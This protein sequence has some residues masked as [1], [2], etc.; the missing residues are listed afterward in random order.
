MMR[1]LALILVAGL[2]GSAT[3][4]R[5]QQA[6]DGRLLV[7][8]P[9]FGTCP[10]EMRLPWAGHV[11]ES[12]LLEL[13]AGSLRV[14]AQEPTDPVMPGTVEQVARQR[15]AELG[16]QAVLW[17]ELA[18][19]GSC[20]A[21][22]TIRLRILD[23]ENEKLLNRELCPEDA[24]FED[25]SRAIALATL[26]ALRSGEVQSLKL[27]E[28]NAPPVRKLAS[29]IDEAPSCPEC[30][31]CPACAPCPETPRPPPC[32]SP[33]ESDVFLTIGGQFSSHP[34]WDSVGFG[35]E[36]GL[37]WAPLSW[38]ELGL[39]LQ[40]LRGR[41]VEV[42]EVHA[43]YTSWPALIWAAFRLVSGTFEVQAAVGLQVAWSRMDVLLPR[44]EVATSIE[45]VNPAIYG[46]VGLRY[47]TPWG[48]GLQLV[49][50]PTVYLR[51]Q[52]YT[53]GTEY[54]TRTVMSMQTV[55]LEAGLHL[56]VPV[57]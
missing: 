29:A 7:V 46:R 43:L 37:S 40:A 30:P 42:D 38:L 4:A 9:I 21:P 24:A 31:E 20:K 15:G 36:A 35:A 25:I 23:L 19:P 16:A 2:L 57:Y 53:Y 44:L 22:R 54:A 5:A 33:W 12:L 27:I 26:A 39:G 8:F 48:F 13:P 49:A 3:T 45:R 6:D 18:P 17:G 50:G 55:S 51:R 41:S 32:P 34:G 47:W 14:E 28:D 1:W 11:A 10:P 52:R 56:V